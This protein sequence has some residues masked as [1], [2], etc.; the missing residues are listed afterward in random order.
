MICPTSS[1]KLVAGVSWL[2]PKLFP[3]PV[4]PLKSSPHWPT[5]AWD[6]SLAAVCVSVV[7]PGL[8]KGPTMTGRASILWIYREVDS[9]G[10]YIRITET[11]E[12]TQ[13]L[14]QLTPSGSMS[15]S[16]HCSCLMCLSKTGPCSW[17]WHSQFSLSPFLPF[18]LPFLLKK[19]KQVFS[20]A[21][22]PASMF[23][24]WHF[25]SVCGAEW[26]SLEAECRQHL[27]ARALPPTLPLLGTSVEGSYMPWIGASFSY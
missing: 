1:D 24:H 10:S 3:W 16:D 23:K 5:E 22:N 14:A 27:C 20:L 11:S 4:N 21:T 8:R 6:I 7:T 9:F 12:E 13:F 19:R 17:M 15:S 2:C 18:F 25:M 26:R